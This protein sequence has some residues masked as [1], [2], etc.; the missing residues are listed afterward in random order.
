MSKRAANFPLQTGPGFILCCEAVASFTVGSCLLLKLKVDGWLRSEPRR[1]TLHPKPGKALTLNSDLDTESATIK[2]KT[3]MK[4]SPSSFFFNLKF[5]KRWKVMTQ[6]QF[7]S[8]SWFP[9]LCLRSDHTRK[10]SLDFTLTGKQ[11][12]LWLYPSNLGERLIYRGPQSH[13]CAR[14]RPLLRRASCRASADQKAGHIV[15]AMTAAPGI[16]STTP[17]KDTIC[18]HMKAQINT[19][20]RRSLEV[21][22]HNK[23]VGNHSNSARPHH[24][25]SYSAV[26]PKNRSS[27][28][29]SISIQS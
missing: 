18:L 15:S 21:L 25:S 6:R 10:D 28:R 24:H 20:N 17:S 7:W 5:E 3:E 22:H 26:N 8:C 1:L 11:L 14:D 19:K 9:E 16:C 27:D 29:H 4:L 2:N 23:D 13:R 12:R